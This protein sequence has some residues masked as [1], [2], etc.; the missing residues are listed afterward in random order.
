V[1]FAGPN[2]PGGAGIFQLLHSDLLARIYASGSS[3]FDGKVGS[4]EQVFS[5]SLDIVDTRDASR[6][7]VRPFDMEG[8]VRDVPD[9]PLVKAGRME[10]IVASKRDAIRFG[11]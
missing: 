10:N 3:V 9:L 5:S 1:I 7:R 6:L 8:V 4:G 2:G 11:Y